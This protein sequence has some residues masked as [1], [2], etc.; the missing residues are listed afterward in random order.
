MLVVLSV[1]SRLVLLITPKKQA[2]HRLLL[3][4]IGPL[5]LTITQKAPLLSALIATNRPPA[6]VLQ[7]RLWAIRPLL[8]EKFLF[9][10]TAGVGLGV[11]ALLIIGGLLPL[12]LEQVQV[13]TVK[14][15]K[16]MVE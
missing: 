6:V 11:G 4:L 7:S 14:L 9:G 1:V 8:I 3:L 12:L 16:R 13:G 2:R 15:Y 5:Q 10:A